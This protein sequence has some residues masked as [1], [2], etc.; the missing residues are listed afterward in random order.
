MTMDRAKGKGKEVLGAGKEKLGEAS[1]D[2]KLRDE[3]AADKLE[4]KGQGM[5]G[6]VK[7]KAEE[8]KKKVT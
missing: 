2:E 6:K 7:E 1:G 3:G 8:I 4:G 5:V